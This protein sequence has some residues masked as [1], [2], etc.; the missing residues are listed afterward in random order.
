MQFRA[1]FINTTHRKLILSSPC[2][3]WTQSVQSVGPKDAIGETVKS[4]F[5]KY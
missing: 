2:E 5:I 4:V 1:L 3:E